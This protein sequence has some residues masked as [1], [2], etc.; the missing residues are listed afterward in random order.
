M[1]ETRPLG[2]FIFK[3]SVALPPSEY[4]PA[5]QLVQPSSADVAPSV[6][7]FWPAGQVCGV[8]AVTEPPVE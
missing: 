6:V 2:Q 5:A 7:A 1:I 3:H 4:L 8:Q